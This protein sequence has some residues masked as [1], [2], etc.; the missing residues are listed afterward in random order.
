MKIA[1]KEN[2]VSERK[3]VY[4]KSF[5]ALTKAPFFRRVKIERE[6]LEREFLS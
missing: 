1:A 5:H 2:F 4:G 3:D 6:K